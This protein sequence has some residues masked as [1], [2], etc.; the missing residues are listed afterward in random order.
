VLKDAL[1]KTEP[2]L[3]AFTT[4]GQEMEQVYSFNPGAHEAPGWRSP[5]R[6]NAEHWLNV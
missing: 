5:H 6:T 2:G 1:H 4:S 3:V